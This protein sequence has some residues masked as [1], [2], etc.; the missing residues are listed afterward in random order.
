MTDRDSGQGSTEF[1]AQ[2]YLHLIE[3]L[4]KQKDVQK[5]VQLIESAIQSYPTNG[6]L[7]YYCGTVYAD[8][9]QF[10]SAKSLI[11]QALNNL[12]DPLPAVLQLGFLHITSGNVELAKTAWIPLEALAEDHSFKLF[13]DGMLK[14]VVDEFADAKRLLELGISNNNLLPGI[15][16]NIEQVIGQINTILNDNADTSDMH[17][18]LLTG[19]DKH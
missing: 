15:N 2:E 10:D 19:Y 16:S 6:E 14:L 12:K 8:N 4:L 5:A 1:S 11:E 7:M 3:H 17:S 13:R 18:R 9:G